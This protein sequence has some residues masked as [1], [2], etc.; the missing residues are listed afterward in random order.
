MALELTLDVDEGNAHTM[1]DSLR[2]SASTSAD[3][4]GRKISLRDMV[5]GLC[6]LL[7]ITITATAWPFVLL[8]SIM[9]AVFVRYLVT[10]WSIS[11]VIMTA[12]VACLVKFGSK[13]LSPIGRYA[14]FGIAVIVWCVGGWLVAGPSLTGDVPVWFSTAAFVT[15]SLWNLW[16]GWT[17]L[18]PITWSRRLRI[19][20]YLFIP[21]VVAAMVLDPSQ[22]TGDEQVIM[23]WRWSARKST[24]S[25]LVPGRNHPTNE[26]IAGDDFPQYLG[27]KRTGRLKGPSLQPQWK[28]NPPSLVW[29]V[30]VGN[31]WSGFALA[32]DLAITQEQRGT[33]EAVT[34]LRITDGER[35]WSYTYSA[36]FIGGPMGDGPRA[37]PTVVGDVVFS[38]GATGVLNALERTSGRLIWTRDLTSETGRTLQIHGNSCSPLVIDDRVFVSPGTQSGSSLV[39]IDKLDG[40][41]LWEKGQATEMYCSPFALPWENDT[42]IVHADSKGLTARLPTDGSIVWN[43]ETTLTGL[44]AQPVILDGFPLRLIIASYDLK[45][46][47]LW[48]IEQSPQH[49]PAITVEWTKPVLKSKFSTP[50]VFGKYVYGL[51]NG[52]LQCV[53]ST[54]GRSL[55]KEGR[56]RHGHLLAVDKHLIVLSEDGELVLVQPDPHQLIELGRVPALEE[57]TWNAMAL[58]GKYL[59]VRNATQAAC[60]SLTL[61]R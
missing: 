54:N 5:R 39:C 21:I 34:A 50:V 27:P 2:T 19:L 23:S 46:A 9:Y 52:I 7:S 58:K 30:P 10:P 14:V 47:S 57:K 48:R 24:S 60:F 16:M 61:S 6:L 49:V 43:H 38:M 8:T 25:T 37:T 13:G 29:R 18:W 15:A 3:R 1:N 44:I 42:I 20:G 53:D 17:F 31:A 28:E 11:L 40:H 36:A 41:T 51:D 59:I 32:G 56:Y 4:R 26:S 22:M 55:W 33:T 45:G 12:L 35:V